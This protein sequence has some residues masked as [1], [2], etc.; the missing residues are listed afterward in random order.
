MA[1]VDFGRYK[2]IVQMF[3]DPEPTN[4]IALDQPVWCL[5]RSY[6]LAGEKPDGSRSGSPSSPPS[7]SSVSRTIPQIQGGSDTLPITAGA[8]SDS[9][10]TNHPRPED[11]GEPQSH[12]GWPSAFLDD[13]ES[14]LWMTYRSDF[15]PIPKSTDPESLS[16]LS[17]QMR[18]KSQLVDQNGFSSDSGWGCMIRS[19]QSLLANTISIQRMGR[20]MYDPTT[21]EPFFL[22][23]IPRFDNRLEARPGQRRGE[24]HHLHVRR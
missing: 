23:L 6:T 13:F 4:D 1:T 9:A 22:T 10:P 19:G 18:M 24:K 21:V 14:K 17:F 11:Q 15:E 20:G 12:G 16:A 5:G 8:S 3:W 2:R 7:S